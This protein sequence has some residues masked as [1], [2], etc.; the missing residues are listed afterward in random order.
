MAGYGHGA[1]AL[2]H[3]DI[4]N[5]LT[6][7]TAAQ[8]DRLIGTLR[9]NDVRVEVNTARTE[10]WGSYFGCHWK[11]LAGHGLVHHCRRPFR[12]DKSTQKVEHLRRASDA[13]NVA[14][15]CA[16]LVDDNNRNRRAARRAGFATVA[17]GPEGARADDILSTLRRNGCL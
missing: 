14:P 9:D 6:Q 3:L 5:T 12:F 17:V 15:Q 7:L 11:P 10:L 1:A 4:D 8:R 2:V 16:V 13:L